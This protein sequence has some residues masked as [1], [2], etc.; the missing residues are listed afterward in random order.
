MSDLHIFVEGR[1][2]INFTVDSMASLE[3]K[4]VELEPGGFWRP[5][6]CTAHH[7]VAIVIP[8]RNRPEQLKVFLAHMHPI[9]Q[10]QQLDYGIYVVEPVGLSIK[11]I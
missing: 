10:R 5:K 9:L 3:R 7:R 6:D 11:V 8:Y 1:V 2:E 4:H